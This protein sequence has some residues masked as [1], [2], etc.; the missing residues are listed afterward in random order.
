MVSRRDLLSA[1]GSTMENTPFMIFYDGLGSS[2]DW[3]II[4]NA[5]GKKTLSHA[6][7]ALSVQL[8]HDF[9]VTRKR[10]KRRTKVA[11]TTTLAAHHP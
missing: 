2:L 11:A 5:D 4:T 6:H 1:F 3:E 8:N 10:I 7:S 9:F